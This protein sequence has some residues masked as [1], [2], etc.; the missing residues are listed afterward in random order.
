MIPFSTQRWN[1]DVRY[2]LHNQKCQTWCKFWILPVWFKFAIMLD[3]ACWL[4]QVGSRLNATW[5]LQTWPTLLKQLPSSLWIKSL[6]N[7]L[8][9]SL[10]TTCSR[11][12][13]IKSKQAMRT[14]PDIVLITARQQAL[15]ADFHSVQFSE[16]S[17]SCDRFLLKCVLSSRTNCIKADSHSVQNVAGSIFSERFLLKCVKSTTANEICSAWL[18]VIQ[19]K[20]LAKS[21]WCD[22]LHWLEIRL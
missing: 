15:K 17:I 1:K 22:I 5:Y 20:A 11:L 19:K 14:H 10:L 12:V 6:D 3:Q 21:R 16:R 18:F 2:S 9:S 13:I 4:H 8:A 7:Q